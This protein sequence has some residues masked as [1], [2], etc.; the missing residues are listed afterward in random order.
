MLTSNARP[1]THGLFNSGVVK[2]AARLIRLDRRINVLTRGDEIRFD[3]VTGSIA[4]RAE[5]AQD[6]RDLVHD[7]RK[8][9]TVG[10]VAQLGHETRIERLN[11]P[12][13]LDRLQEGG[14][15]RAPRLPFQH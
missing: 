14:G 2:L 8:A 11:T 3:P 13:A 10:Q 7:D 1:A 9:M 6:V 12:L 4:A 5:V 15:H